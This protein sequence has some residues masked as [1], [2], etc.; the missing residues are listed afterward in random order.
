MTS[1][2]GTKELIENK[3]VGF[4]TKSNS[5]AEH[6]KSVLY[7]ELFKKFPREFINRIDE[8]ILFNKLLTWLEKPNVLATVKTI[9]YKIISGSTTFVIVYLFTG[10]VKTSGESTLVM[11]GIHMVQFWIHE[12]LW[13]IW[14]NNRKNTA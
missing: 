7:K 8:K 9:T 1:N 5:V 14:E 12:R 13:L 2:V 3:S 10:N 4:A 6:E 11:M